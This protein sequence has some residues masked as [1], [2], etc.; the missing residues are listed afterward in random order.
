MKVISEFVSLCLFFSEYLDEDEK[1]FERL[2][3]STRYYG[4][5]CTRDS[6]SLPKVSVDYSFIFYRIDIMSL[7]NFQRLLNQ[8]GT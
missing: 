8:Y 5:Q 7:T 6:F 2:N 1:A 4:V 3:N